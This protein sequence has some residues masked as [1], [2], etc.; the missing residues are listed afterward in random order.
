MTSYCDFAPGHEWHG[1]YH[2][3]EYGFPLRDD[4]ELFQRL[5][6]EINQAGL[7]WLLILKKRAAFARA[8]DGFDID[9]VAA[10]G[11]ADVERLLSDEGIIRNK[12]KVNAAIHNAR[13]LQDIRAEWGG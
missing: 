12:L 8:F 4:R 3:R 11:P 1:P 10:Y 6:L 13:V 5:A 2:D 7:N 9:R